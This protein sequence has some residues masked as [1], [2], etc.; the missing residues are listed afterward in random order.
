MSTSSVR[1]PFAGTPILSEVVVVGY[2]Y[3]SISIQTLWRWRDSFDK[4]YS[5]QPR[6]LTDFKMENLYLNPVQ[7]GNDGCVR[8]ATKSHFS[9]PVLL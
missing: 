1:M 2:P 4:V 8:C 7:L 6:T 3:S 5:L 9:T